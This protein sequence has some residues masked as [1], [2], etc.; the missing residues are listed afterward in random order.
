MSSRTRSKHRKTQPIA[1]ADH[2][3][4]NTSP[5]RDSHPLIRLQQVIGN[6]GTQRLLQREGWVFNPVQPD[7]GLDPN[8]PGSFRNQYLRPRQRVEIYLNSQAESLKQSPKKLL[9]TVGLVRQSVRD[10]AEMD[11]AELQQIITT[12]AMPNG[13]LIQSPTTAIQ[14]L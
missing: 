13:I 2:S 6:Q 12:W 1:I 8:S 11:T 7:I 4:E 14:H 9:D 5:V 10:A 3:I